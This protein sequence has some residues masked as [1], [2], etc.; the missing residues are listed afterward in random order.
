MMQEQYEFEERCMCSL[1]FA[2]QMLVWGMRYWVR[3]YR[4]G[5]DPLPY[6]RKG[7]LQNGIHGAAEALDALMLVVSATSRCTIDMRCMRFPK[8]SVDEERLIA[9]FAEAHERDE[10]PAAAEFSRPLARDEAWPASQAAGRPGTKSVPAG[11]IG[12]RA[13]FYSHDGVD[14]DLLAV[15]LPPTAMQLAWGHA[16]EVAD[17]FT[18]AGIEIRQDRN[19]RPY[20]IAGETIQGQAAE[21][22]TLH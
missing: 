3:C 17:A 12:T 15:W 1:R 19:V 14:D 13:R 2:P 4:N 10:F 22:R 21:T 7:F 16:K 5:D 6:L 8:L 20:P 9:V 11:D 18:A